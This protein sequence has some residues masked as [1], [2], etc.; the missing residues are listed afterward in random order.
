MAR[1]DS[2]TDY[3]NAV[4]AAQHPDGIPK[5]KRE[6]AF[7]EE[8][9]VTLHRNEHE[10]RARGVDHLL[11]LQPYDFKGTM[12]LWRDDVGEL[13]LALARHLT[14]RV[15][16]AAGEDMTCVVPVITEAD[17]TKQVNRY[18]TTA[19]S[20]LRRVYGGSPAD[21]VVDLIDSDP[22]FVAWRDVRPYDFCKGGLN[23]WIKKDGTPNHSLARELTHN[24]VSTLKEERTWT[25]ETLIASISTADMK[26][27]ATRYGATL[28]GMAQSI[29]RDSVAE[30]VIDL[31][32]HDDRYTAYRDVRPYDFARAPNKTWVRKDGT[33]N[34]NLARELTHAVLSAL[35]KHRPLMDVIAHVNFEEFCTTPV[36][37]YGTTASG[38]LQMVYNDSHAHAIMDLV[39]HDKRYAQC[40]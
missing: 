31:I 20:M 19:T 2:L 9:I 39:T 14:K 4:I 28:S 27:A 23:M 8:L 13:N 36:N 18:G 34:Y 24:L 29:Y 38:M 1:K 17:F 26:H 32:A 30:A 11:Q 3:V 6:L 37:R 7:I 10:L 5:K 35:L 22:D 15:V 16:R 12:H 21:A 33:K 25:M 40:S